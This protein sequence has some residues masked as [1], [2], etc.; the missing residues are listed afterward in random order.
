MGRN[1]AYLPAYHVDKKIVP[2]GD[3]FIV[4]KDGAVRELCAGAGEDLEI[5][6]TAT[7]P[8]TPDADTRVSKPMIVVKPGKAYELFV[9][10]DGW[11]SLG[12]QT[13]GEEPVSF[14]AVPA[15]GL[16]WMVA[17]GS[18][19]LERIFTIEDGKQIWW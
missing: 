8:E 2:A 3:P 11:K 12:K 5:E 4:T 13:A 15:G 19:K 7:A 18:R 6:I 1:I 16:Y 17:E 14:T 9:W 10:E